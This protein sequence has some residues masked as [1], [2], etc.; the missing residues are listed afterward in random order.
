MCISLIISN[1]AAFKT[2]QNVSK[3]CVFCNSSNVVKNGHKGGKQ[4]YKCKKCSRQFVGGFRL[5]SMKIE[6]D[7]VDGKQTL[8]QLSLKY[9]VCVKTIWNTLA[10]MRHKR[11]VSK[12]KDGVVEMDAP[13]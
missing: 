10:S 9:G 2:V 4:L 8:K 6:R 5:D 7:Y 11:V 13:Y 1:F 3:K 12:H